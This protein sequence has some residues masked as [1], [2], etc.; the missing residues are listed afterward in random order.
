MSQN[1]IEQARNL[2]Q[3]F[4]AFNRMS[5]QLES[6][7]RDLENKVSALN[8]ELAAARSERLQQ[9]AEKERLAD[10]LE[11]LLELLPGGVLVLD[12]QGCVSQTNPMAEALFE[13]GLPGKFWTAVMAEHFEH[14]LT[15]Y[16][17]VMLKNGKH[18]TISMRPLDA[19]P[20]QIVLI[21]DV[22]DQH[23]LKAM[24]NRQDRLAVMGEMAA[25]LAHQIRTPLTT[26][27]LYASNV[28]KEN[29]NTTDRQRMSTKV[30]ERLN[31][32][33]HMVNDML[34]FTR[35]SSFVA[36]TI[37]LH[38]LL[39]EFRQIMEP[40][41]ELTGGSLSLPEHHESI[42][43]Q[44][45]HDALLGVFLNLANNALQSCGENTAITIASS[46]IDSRI[47]I[48]F[49]DNGPGIAANI[50]EK[51]FTPFYTTR[52]EGTGL[53]LA[54]AQATLRAH[55]GEIKYLPQQG[56]GA[57]FTIDLPL[58]DSNSM[59][60]SGNSSMK[61]EFQQTRSMRS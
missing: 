2:E 21:M 61:E 42:E 53:G 6:S 43:L 55:D 36:A 35:G 47:N 18:V 52:S 58:V 7:Y 1:S 23:E 22:S 45:D 48:V 57:T 50:A 8:E 14:R 34:R 54:V 24:L 44:G 19:E 5:V 29:L 20:G 37:D 15:E 10:R 40:Q 56:K 32:L 26:A 39:E 16:G 33:E 49:A 30:V 17:E 4:S 27:L 59:L 25:S 38:A 28:Q 31:H 9:L 11:R 12:A 13:Q 60:P 46:V 51:I 41:V 3:A